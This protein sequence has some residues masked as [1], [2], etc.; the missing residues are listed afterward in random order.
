[1]AV[2]SDRSTCSPCYRGRA[3]GGHDDG[4]DR[5]GER[6]Y[7]G[8]EIMGKP[9]HSLIKRYD[10]ILERKLGSPPDKALLPVWRGHHR[11]RGDRE[12]ARVQKD[13]AWQQ[14]NAYLQCQ[15]LLDRF[16]AVTK[17]LRSINVRCNIGGSYLIAP[18]LDLPP[19]GRCTNFS[20]RCPEVIMCSCI[21]RE[22]EP[23]RAL[24]RP[25]GSLNFRVDDMSC[26]HCASTISK[27]IEIA[28][29]GAA[30]DADLQS[31]IVSVRGAKD[32]S[33]IQTIIAEAGY[34]AVPA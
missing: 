6:D 27:A 15:K 25:V 5:E 26:G 30:V 31:K 10:F 33:R 1:M 2:R 16:A 20:Q 18:A 19:A 17:F 11:P 34:Q 22:I 21:T 13:Q 32:P 8:N 24:E 28:M 14:R 12:R 23:G 29:P 7:R 4:R 3:H 9:T